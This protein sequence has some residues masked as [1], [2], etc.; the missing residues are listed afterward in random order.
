MDATANGARTTHL[1][2]MWGV[3]KSDHGCDCK[4]SRD[5]TLAGGEG[6]ATVRSQMRMQ[7]EQVQLTIWRERGSVMGSDH[8]RDCK[9]SKG[10]LHSGDGEGARCRQITD[11]TENGAEQRTCWIWW[12]CRESAMDLF[13]DTSQKGIETT[14]I[15]DDRNGV[16]LWM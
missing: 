8:R 4:R 5:D 12:R 3:I 13:P 1:L 14:H 15:L 11:V 9:E 6:G 10:N 2:E 7:K 16:R